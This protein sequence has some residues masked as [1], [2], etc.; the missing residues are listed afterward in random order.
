MELTP[1]N[2]THPE[3]GSCICDIR[4]L[5]ILEKQGWKKQT[6]GAPTGK[7][8]AAQADPIISDS[9]IDDLIDLDAIGEVLAPQVA[10]LLEDKSLD[11]LKA[12]LGTKAGRKALIALNGLSAAGVKKIEA[13]L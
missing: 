9:F 2:L 10:D 8:V 1:I 3:K 11:G 6:T 13:Q 12:Y 7:K 5:A 4:Q